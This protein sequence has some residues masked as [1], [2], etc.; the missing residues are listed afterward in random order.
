LGDG[1]GGA[2]GGIDER[3]EAAQAQA[4]GFQGGHGV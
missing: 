1:D 2:V 3:D 4:G